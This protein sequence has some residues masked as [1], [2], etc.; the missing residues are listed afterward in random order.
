MLA[1][2]KWRMANTRAHYVEP[3]SRYAL[4]YA[5]HYYARHITGRS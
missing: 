2:S 3:I 5:K 4:G 1:N